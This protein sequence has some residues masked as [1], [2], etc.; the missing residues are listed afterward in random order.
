MHIKS[1]H[2]IISKDNEEGI[3]SRSTTSFIQL[4]NYENGFSTKELIQYFI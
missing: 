2:S 4:Q 1:L 3:F